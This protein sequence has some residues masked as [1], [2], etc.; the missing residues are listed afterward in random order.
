VTDRYIYAIATMDTK[1]AEICFI[2]DQL[3]RA[4]LMVKTVD[5]GTAADAQK[6]PDVSREIIAAHH[7]K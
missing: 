5:V 6:K 4:G 3:Q 7:A 2:A 1:G